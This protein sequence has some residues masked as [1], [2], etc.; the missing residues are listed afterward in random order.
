[1]YL[2]CCISLY[3]LNTAHGNRLFQIVI[4]FCCHSNQRSATPLYVTP[5]SFSELYHANKYYCY[6]TVIQFLRAIVMNIVD[7]YESHFVANNNCV[8]Y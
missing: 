7:W 8:G 3:C 1:M 2:L 5:L 4:L 6:P